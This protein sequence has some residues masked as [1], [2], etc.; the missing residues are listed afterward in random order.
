ML[1]NVYLTIM[2]LEFLPTWIYWQDRK[3]KHTNISYKPMA[4]RQVQYCNIYWPERCH[5]SSMYLAAVIGQTKYNIQR[6]AVF[7]RIFRNLIHFGK[8]LFEN[9]RIIDIHQ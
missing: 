6:K 1:Y 8:L 7:S 5:S 9:I 3:T 2:M 4:G